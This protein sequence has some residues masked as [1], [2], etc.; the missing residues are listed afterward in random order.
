MRD[1]NIYQ[2]EYKNNPFEEHLIFYRHRKTLEFLRKHH[3]KNILEIGCGLRPLYEYYTDFDSLVI[4]EP[5]EDFC[6]EVKRLKPAN[7]ILMEGV[8]DGALVEKLK[9]KF[10]FIVI[11]SLLHELDNPA[12]LVKA[13]ISVAS[14]ETFFHINVPNAKSFHRLL[15]LKMG[16]IS[17]LY[18]KSERQHRYQQN[19]TFDLDSL[20]KLLKECGLIIESKGSIFIKPFTH[21]QMQA[22]LD[23]EVFSS[24]LLEG[25]DALV[26]EFPDNG[27]E[28][29]VNGRINE[30]I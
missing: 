5:S 8:F 18:E 12:E 2:D 7:V 23:K 29:F 3:A 11:S 16:L 15:A 27:A 10:D 26:S 20:T 14:P 13:A 28:I 21:Q 9:E 25:L 17:S 1:I 24:D 19:T 30:G 22:L 6:A 4:V